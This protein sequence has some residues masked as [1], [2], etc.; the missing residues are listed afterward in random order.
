[1]DLGVLDAVPEAGDVDAVDGLVAGF[2][3]RGER[4]AERAAVLRSAGG[5]LAAASAGAWAGALGDRALR[6][7]VGLDD[8]AQGCRQVAGVLAGYAAAL[9][10]LERRVMVARHEVAT[11]R[12]RAV[13]ARER[14]EVAVAA[15]GGVVPGWSWTDPPAFAVVA[16]A[17]S[18]A[19]AWRAAVAD[20]A[21]GLRGFEECCREREELDRAT[22][23]GLRGVDLMSAYA[24]GAGGDD[25]LDVPLVQALAAVAAGTPTMTQ[26]SLLA[27]WFADGVERVADD[28]AGSESS[29][30]LARFLEQWGGDAPMM[31]AVLLEVGGAGVL[32][33]LLALGG[34]TLAGD[35]AR[36]AA[37]T[38]LAARVRSGLAVA[39]S[40]WPSADARRFAADLVEAAADR[41]GH[42]GPSVVGYL[43]DDPVTARMGEH[44]TVAVADE[45]DRRERGQGPWRD[46][47]GSSG[48]SLGAA[49]SVDDGRS[50]VHDPASRVFTTLGTYP[51][52][53]REWLTGTGVDWTA[54]VPAFDRTRI[55]YWFGERDWSVAASDGFAGI[56]ALWAGMQTATECSTV[57][58]V[59]AIND[60]VFEGLAV[61]P[62]LLLTEQV[63]SGGAQHLAQALAAQLPGL[64]EVGVLRGPSGAQLTWELV[65]APH[66]AGGLVTGAVDRGEFGRVLAAATSDAAGRDVVQD[67]LLGYQADVL[68]AAGDG[69][70]SADQ[71][72]DRLAAAWGVADGAIEGATQAELQRASDR[73][74]DTL[75]LVRVP[76]DV[77]LT[78]VSNPL[79]AIGLDLATDHLERIA[80]SHLVPDAVSGVSVRPDAAQ[81]MDDFFTAAVQTYQDAGLWDQPTV[82]TDG[83]PATPASAAAMRYVT[84]YDVVSAAMSAALEEP[85]NAGTTKEDG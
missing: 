48:Y 55:D 16:S 80:V 38:S 72:L 46:G 18:E 73:V 67:A 63:S 6:P 7:S 82:R 70:A 25:V 14:Y 66:V 40:S 84:T 45:I 65:P 2:V 3:A 47:H 81:P 75:G 44:L 79:V 15:G 58:H 20:A 59:A 85:V 54:E 30:R 76:V 69:G 37:V 83:Q 34:S 39:S 27:A 10:A 53:A 62:M 21:A 64:V 8:A 41:T 42:G 19:R 78:G 61:N 33:L 26:R 32:R 36:N 35:S 28:P 77:A 5:E 51:D 1:V 29:E 4:F 22:A 43:F 56:G 11:A 71:A 9:R 23:A 49:G 52:A 74:R 24:P 13:A 57:H 12:I 50:G 60:A 68:V 31:S 17:A